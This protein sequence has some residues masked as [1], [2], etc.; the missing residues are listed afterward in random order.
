MSKKKKSDVYCVIGLGR[1]GS[2]AA[3]YLAEAGCEVMVI[4]A[5][6]SKV[7]ELRPFTA[8]AFV[9]NDLGIDNLREMG[10][11]D[12][13]TVIIGIGGAID[14]SVLTALH[15]INL[16]VPRVIAKAVSTEHGEL[17]QKLGAESIY[18]E[19]DM[20]IRLG[21]QLT[22]NTVMEYISL[23]NNMEISEVEI[24]GWLSGKTL[25]DA[26]LREK[27]SVN[28]IALSH[29]QDGEVETNLDPNAVLREGDVMVV[30]GK[31]EDIRRFENDL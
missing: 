4:D 1:F 18:P 8:L 23:S 12:C 10:V 26:A 31:S 14:V 19:R 13:S 17:L 6:E 30:L 28:I 15:V 21:K 2:A 11:G 7:R 27:Y 20:A 16:G 29:S 25:M 3:K 22:T 5:V 9:T 24:S